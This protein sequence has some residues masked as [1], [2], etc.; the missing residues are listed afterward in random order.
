VAKLREIRSDVFLVGN[1]C[2][3]RDCPDCGMAVPVNGPVRVTACPNCQTQV[4]VP[5]QAWQLALRTGVGLLLQ[6]APVTCAGAMVAGRSKLEIERKAQDDPTCVHCGAPL[7]V[8]RNSWREPA[9]SVTCGACSRRVD[10]LP[11]PFQA[12]SRSVKWTHFAGSETEGTVPAHALPV[13]TGRGGDAQAAVVMA[14]PS[15]GGALKI[16]ADTQRTTS[17]EFCG[18]SVY[19]PDDLWRR[20]HPAKKAQPWISVHTTT[21]G[22]LRMAGVTSVVVTIIVC[23]LFSAGLLAGLSV[24]VYAALFKGAPPAIGVICALIGLPVVVAVLAI[25]GS[26]IGKA[27]AYYRAAAQLQGMPK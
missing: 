18:S 15:C 16:A 20:L 7:S 5:E 22:D 24:G 14:C 23:V 11:P 8:S 2:M 3:V 4:A 25:V 21:P 13:E 10:F 17:C 6:D 27:G 9:F 19:L 12:G 26:S 1:K